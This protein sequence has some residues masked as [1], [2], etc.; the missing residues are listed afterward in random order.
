MKQEL[1]RIESALH[2]LAQPKPTDSQKTSTATGEQTDG[3]EGQSVR[4]RD[5][6]ELSFSMAVQ[7]FPAKKQQSKTPT[8]PKIKPPSFSEHRHAA[9]PALAMN[10]LQEIEEIVARWQQELQ[11]IGRQ[12]QDIYIEGPIVDGWLESHSR[13]A[14]EDIGSVRPATSDRLMDYVPEVL[15]HS[16]E[17][18]TCESPRTGYRLCG[19]NAD[20]Q[21]WSRPCPP[22][23]VPSVSLAIARYQKLRQL[24][25]RKQDLE[26]RLSQLAETL[27]VMHAHLSKD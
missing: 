1:Q 2:Q 22:D 20:G 26:T 7:P 17:K 12:I 4:Q 23:Q 24:L 27:V 16:D 13:E 3:V 25:S 8:L 9:N 11:T 10:L 18:V 5:A 19:L 21:F 15:E 6:G 14:K